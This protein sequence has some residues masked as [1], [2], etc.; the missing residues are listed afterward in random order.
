MLVTR[1]IASASV[2]APAMLLT[3]ALVLGSDST[4]QRTVDRELRAERFVLVDRSGTERGELAALEDGSAR[5]LV[6]GKSG[7]RSASVSA[8]A[9]GTLRVTL[10]RDDGHAALELGLTEKQEPLLVMYDATHTRRFGALCLGSGT[11]GMQLRDA[12]GRTRAELKILVDGSPA[13]V[14]NGEDPKSRVSLSNVSSGGAALDFGDKR[15]E[16]RLTIGLNDTGGAV[17]MAFDANGA[18]RWSPKELLKGP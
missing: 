2:G 8:D 15:G 17:I 12:K 9:D 11:V 5:V 13:L 7:A 6:R 4:K 1:S 16:N 3:L 10:S 14:L 18:P